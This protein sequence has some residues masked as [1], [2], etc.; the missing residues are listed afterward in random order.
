MRIL[1]TGGTGYIGTA[2][3]RAIKDEGHDVRL[4]VRTQSAQKIDAREGYDVVVG[5]VLDTQTCMRATEECDAIVHLIGIRREFPHDGITYEAMHTEATYALVDAAVRRKVPRIIYMSSQGARPDATSRY[6]KT[7]WES[8]ELVRKSGM[9]YTIFRPS[10][11]FGP[12][13]E[14]HLLLAELVHKKVVPVIDGGK[15]LLQPVA[16]HNVI[17]AMARSLVMPETQGKEIEV[18]GPERVKFI[19]IMYAV[20][21]HYGVWPNTMPLPSL[22]AKP[23]VK[24]MQGVVPNF[25][26]TYDELLLLLEDNVCDNAEFLRLFGGTLDTYTD[27]IPSLCPHIYELADKPATSSHHA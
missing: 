5:D 24:A 15:S 4:L 26:L 21:R 25:P 22:V 3:R 12:G 6:H 23:L 1:L 9:R 17:P 11:I 8:E 10:V 18:G 2:L 20:A 16:L 13:D 27:K 14:F 19:D 7:K